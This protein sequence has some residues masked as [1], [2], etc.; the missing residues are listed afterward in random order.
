MQCTV[1]WNEF[2][3]SRAVED[4]YVNPVAIDAKLDGHTIWSY[5]RQHL[6]EISFRGR[7]VKRKVN[8][9]DFDDQ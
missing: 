9:F 8:L 3:L 5:S 7:D 1:N 2:G 6:T 4:P